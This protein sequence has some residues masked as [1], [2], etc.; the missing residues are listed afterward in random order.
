MSQGQLYRVEKINSPIHFIIN[1]KDFYLKDFDTFDSYFSDKNK[2]LAKKHNINEIEAFIIGNLA[3]YWAKNLLEGREVLVL[4]NKDLL[5]SKNS[6]KDKFFYSGFCIK[7]S[8]LCSEEA[9]KSLI[10]NIKNSKYVLLDLETDKIYTISKD[11][12]EHLK[13]FLVIK[14]SHIKNQ[15][16]KENCINE[17]SNTDIKIYFTDSTEKLFPEN[18]CSSGICKEI[19]RNINNAKSS[20]DIAIYGYS[21]VPEI[22]KAIENA[23]KRNVKIRLVYDQDN[24]GKNI[25]PNTDKIVSLIP[26]NK[27]DILSDESKYI[28]HNKFYIFDNETLITG[29]ANLSHTDMSG[30][31][32]NSVMVIKSKEVAN[33]YKTEFEQMYSG[34]FHNKKIS[35]P[36][37]HIK[38]ANVILDIYFSPQDKTIT[39]VILP[40]IRNAKNY[41]YI[42]TFVLTDYKVTE[43]LIKAK[44][45]GVDVK[46]IIDALNASIKHTKHNNLR[47]GGVLVKTENYAGKMH[48]KSMIIDD[49]YTIIGSMNF[50]YS[51][52]NKNDENLVLITDTK[53]AKQYKN[54]FLS[55]WNKI[56]DKWLNMNVRAESQDSIGSCNDGIDNNYD[57]YT[58]KFDIACKES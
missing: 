30:F 37:K 35:H 41:I 14:K 54:F 24:E 34:N 45:R 7:D 36:K 52:E 28:M 43:E 58:D 39:K 17:I 4:N 50:S 40:L 11:N 55:Q 16:N 9:F 49:K 27:S 21:Y 13:N 33:I 12:V 20:I 53:I 2:N 56:D 51:G 44:K 46:I 42:P 8:K 1:N 31:N 5:F 38:V 25:Y 6:Y 22:E 10:S 29:S 26:Q 57:G 23:I 32:S 47:L 15:L 19:L 3:N 18:H 48:S